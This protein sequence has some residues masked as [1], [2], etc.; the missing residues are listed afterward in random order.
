MEWY[1][2]FNEKGQKIWTIIES[3]AFSRAR[4]YNSEVFKVWKK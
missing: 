4:F 2:Y 1:Y 3:V